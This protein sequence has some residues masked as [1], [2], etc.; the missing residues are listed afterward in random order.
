MHNEKQPQRRYNSAAPVY[1]NLAQPPADHGDGGGGGEPPAEKRYKEKRA[2]NKKRILAIILS[3]V[4]LLIIAGLAAGYFLLDKKYS[5]AIDDLDRNRP[6]IALK[7]FEEIKWFKESDEYI[8]KCNTLITYN[9]AVN[10]YSEGYYKEALSVFS[11]LGDY[12]ES[13]S[14]AQLCQKYIDYTQAIR[15]FED[16]GFKEAKDIYDELGEFEDSENMAV[17]CQ[18]N[19]DYIQAKA[20]FEE[21]DYEAAN[22]LFERIPG[23]E[24]SSDMIFY[25]DCMIRYNE[26]LE[27]IDKGSFSDA[28]KALEKIKEDV[29]GTSLDFSEILPMEELN[30]NMGKGYFGDELYYSAYNAFKVAGGYKDAAAMLDK[31]IQTVDTD[32]TYI[33]PDYTKDTVEMIYY[34]PKDRGSNIYVEVYQD[35]TLVSTCLIK[36]DEKLKVKYPAGKYTFKI[37]EGDEWFGPKE[38]FGTSIVT[39][40]IVKT[41]ESNYNYWINF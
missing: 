22:E 14:Y 28:T 35:D 2:K 29:L 15:L 41:L 39:D 25:C 36:Y 10:A 38:K 9:E 21:K 12:E 7:S 3:S 4:A 6:R 5:D 34:G 30:Y 24:D 40:S 20:Y 27:D 13:E 19:I 37:Y 8:L 32:E 17:M 16:K 23:F 31:C 11:D 26:A 33:N 1:Q 18:N